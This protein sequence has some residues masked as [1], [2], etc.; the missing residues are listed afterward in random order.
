MTALEKA[1][2]EYTRWLGASPMNVQLLFWNPGPNVRLSPDEVARELLWGEEVH[3]LIDLPV[4]EIIDRLKAEFPKSE[5]QPGLLVAN[6]SAGSFEATWTWQY[7]RVDGHGLPAADR[8]R[9]IEAVESFGCM[10]Y[11]VSQAGA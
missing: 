3:G 8:Q 4:K 1:P 7:V 11:D 2:F 10:A 5:E 9:L 6:A